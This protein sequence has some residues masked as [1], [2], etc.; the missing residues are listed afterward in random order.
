MKIGVRRYDVR[1]DV[2]PV[3]GGVEPGEMR[4][5]I[6]IRMMG[7]VLEVLLS[8]WESVAWVMKERVE[9]IGVVDRISM[10]KDQRIVLDA[11]NV[12]ESVQHRLF[13]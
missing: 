10:S 9:L 13:R 2:T 11:E 12:F 4:Q 7:L 1:I 3:Q 6:E 8:N 5:V